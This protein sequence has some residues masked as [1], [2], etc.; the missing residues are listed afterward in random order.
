MPP[1]A[2]D[3]TMETIL[4]GT[5]LAELLGV[6]GPSL[7][8][9]AREGYNCAGYPVHEWAVEYKS[10]R[11]KGYDVPGAILVK[12]NWKSKRKDRDNPE[13]TDLSNDTKPVHEKGKS[14]K[15][16][17]VTNNYSLLPAEQSYVGTTGMATIPF[18]LKEAL[19][20][21]TP[22]SRA[23]IGGG[24]SLL[25]GITAYSMTDNA[26]GGLVGAATGLGIAYAFMQETEHQENVIRHLPPASNSQQPLREN[27][28]NQVAIHS[29]FVNLV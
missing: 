29:D 17:S 4:T 12:H 3:V 10:G 5:E 7:S 27:S 26:G 9:A 8:E 23:V 25:F 19:A 1:D 2:E 21:D 16:K 20:N 11:I 24:L 15:Q 14:D 18:V 13:E 6:A 22:L 28:S